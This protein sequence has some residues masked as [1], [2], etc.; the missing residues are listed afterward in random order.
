MTNEAPPWNLR[1]GI[2][3]PETLKVLRIHDLL[4]TEYGDHPW[5]PRDPVATLVSAILS[6]NTNDVNRDRAF[7]R[8]RARFP[9]WEAVR[10]APLPDLIEAIRPAGLAPTK[11]PRIQ[12]ALRRITEERGEISMDFLS[13]MGVE[14]AR[15]WLLSLPGVGPKTAAIVLCFAL[16]KPAFPVDT[17]VHRVARRLGL[18]PERASREKAHE[19]LEVVVPREI[20]Y[21]FHL[22]LIAHGRAVCHART[23]RCEDCVLR[24]ECAHYITSRRQRATGGEQSTTLQII[25]VRHAETVANV[26]GRWVGWGDTGLTER[27]R[28]QVE[29]TARRLVQEVHDG[30][31]I[32]TSPLPRARETAE[33]IGRALGLK[34]IPV[35]NL[36]EINFGD[37]DGVTLE[38]MRTRY[39]DL[40]AR[41]RDKTDG[42]YTWPGGEKRADFFRRVA[43]VCQEILSRHDR[44]TVIIV[45]HGGTVRACL[46]HLM[47][48][49]LGEWWGYSLDN[50]GITRLQIEDGTVRLLTLNDISHLP[51]VKREEL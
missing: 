49:K 47:P 51:E 2:P 35:E 27:G 6:Q 45:A 1:R 8:L 37:L 26:E 23:P 33:G 17:H 20:Y 14:E 15:R 5:H 40:Y 9:T 10:D 41:W 28:V 44:G 11:A 21:P 36:R 42:E 24:E 29:A 22:N 16:G 50:C 34:P 3:K 46:A 39:P 48:D 32:Y 43:E 31:A 4:L 30:A 12:E 38:E 7:E 25:L 18:I 13:E 19:L